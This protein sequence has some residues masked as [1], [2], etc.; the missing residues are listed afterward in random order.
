MWEK[1]KL[2]VTSNFSFSH[3]VFKRLQLQ[4]SKNQGL[5]GKGLTLYHTIKR[6][7][8]DPVKEAFWK[9]CRKRRKCWEPAF[10]PFPTMFSTLSKTNFNFSP[11]FILSSAN[12]FNLDQSKI[13][14][15][16][17]ELRVMK[18]KT[19]GIFL[20]TGWETEKAL[21]TR[22]LLI[23]PQ[24]FYPFREIFNPLIFSSVNASKV[25]NSPTILMNILSF[26][27]FFSACEFLFFGS[28]KVTKFLVDYS[29]RM[30]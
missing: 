22:F 30:V 11:A 27:L 28:F 3:I 24:C 4:T 23:F 17:K 18:K 14:S 15:F 21:M 7:F 13:L 2:I 19:L 8:N 20:E 12:A 6:Q 16:G 25:R 29:N 5:F 9:H 10:S 1:E 26:S